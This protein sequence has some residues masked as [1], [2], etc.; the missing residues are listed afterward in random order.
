MRCG[1]A[2]AA[3]VEHPCQQLLGGLGG[4]DVEQLLVLLAGEHQTRLELQ[5]GGDQHD[6][7]SG[8]LEIE[9]TAGLEVVEVGE[10]DLGELQLQE[11]DL[12]A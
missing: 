5:Q 9:L 10:H 3:G 4:L 12:F 2:V 8:G 7:L 11:V 1:R 6:E